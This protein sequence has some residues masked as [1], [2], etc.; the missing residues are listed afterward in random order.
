[1]EKTGSRKT[2]ITVAVLM[3]AA[4]LALALGGPS[5]GGGSGGGGDDTGQ[6]SGDYIV[7]AWNDLGMHCLN[8]T[9]D[10]AVILPPYNTI[11]AVVI[12]RGNPP[13]VVVTG[14]TVEY[15]ILDNTFSYGKQSFGQF[16]DNVLALFGVDLARDTGL[17]LVDENT[18]N[19]LSG[20][21]VANADHFQVDGVPLTPVKDDGSRTPYQVAEITVK[22][23][24]GNTLATTRCTA[25]TSDEINC[26]KCHG[27]GSVASAFNDVLADHDANT[28]STLAAQTP[29]LCADCHGSPALGSSGRGSSG[30]YL[31]E[32]MHGAHASRGAECYDC[33]PGQTDKCSRSL[34]HTAADGNCQT[35]HGDMTQVGDAARTPWTDEPAC[36]DCHSVTGVDTGATLYRNAQGHGDLYCPTCHGSPHAMVPSR[37]AAD[38]YQAQQ[39][40]SASV[41]MG[42][43]AACHE[44]SRGEDELDEFGEKHGGTNPEEET[45]CHVCHTAVSTT[46]ADWP[47]SFDWQDR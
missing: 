11:W 35:C 9:Y 3:L 14:L 25:P 18:H 22:D 47:H 19:G 34:R 32:A 8:P 29:V 37:E 15:R 31:S 10:T 42:S 27:S 2:R 45:A 16:W 5:C 7:F 38:N 39:Y 21:M 43:C 4:T 46:R 44:S 40:M 23:S 6:T 13:Q 41:S 12:K 33:H 30:K 20:E 1:M 17:N 26:A 36:A 24:S 28:G